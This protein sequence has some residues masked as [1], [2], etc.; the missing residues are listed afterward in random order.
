MGCR[1]KDQVQDCVHELSDDRHLRLGVNSLART[2]EVLGSESVR[3]E[4][5]TILVAVAV[6]ARLA[7]TAGGVASAR[8]VGRARVGSE[9]SRDRVLIME[10]QQVCRAEAV[11]G[12]TYSLPDI[13]L[14]TARAAV[15]GS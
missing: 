8:S 13:H 5:T 15:A 3:V 1:T 14:S 12:Y 7:R 9:G 2:E 4:I 11:M 6:V 10:G